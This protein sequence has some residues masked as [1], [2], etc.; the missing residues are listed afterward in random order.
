MEGGGEGGE[1]W[2]R[3]EGGG[4]EEAEREREKGGGEGGEGREGCYLLPGVVSVD[5]SGRRRPCTACSDNGLCI[6]VC[7]LRTG[8]DHRSPRPLLQNSTI[9][10][11][12]K[13]ELS[14]HS[15]RFQCLS[16]PSGAIGVHN[17]G[18]RV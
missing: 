15:N 9:L 14:K 11:C 2:T 4:K 5:H 8:L 13:C 16:T 10:Q 1:R 18:C 7:Q 3:E 12:T 6:P 17:R